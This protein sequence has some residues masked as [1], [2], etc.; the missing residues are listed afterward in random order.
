[1]Q[2]GAVHLVQP[3]PAHQVYRVCHYLYLQRQQRQQGK[4]HGQRHQGAQP[5]ATKTEGQQIRQGA[6]LVEATDAHDRKHEHR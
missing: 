3:V 4:Q 2:G 6:E 1:M 5:R